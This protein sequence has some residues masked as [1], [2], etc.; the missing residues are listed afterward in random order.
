MPPSI[1]PE[2]ELLPPSYGG[3]PSSRQIPDYDR[4]MSR[5]NSRQ[6]GWNI[7][8]TPG[9]Y[10]LLGINCAVYIW[11]V[12]RGVSPSEP[13]PR[14]LIHFGAAQASLI[15]HGQWYRLITA[16]FV[17]VGLLHIATNMWC[18]WN[19]GLLGEPLLGPFG[20]IAVY[21][22]TGIAGNLLSL[23]INVV[24]RD[25]SV[26]AG[27]SGAVFGIA[28]IL[29]V[30]LSN[31]K[32]PIPWSELKRLRK[33]VIWFAAINLLI[34]GATLFVPV[35]R[36]DNFAHL[37]GFLSGLALGVPLIPR[38]TSGRVRY[39]RRQKYTFAAASFG[40]ALFGYWIANL[41]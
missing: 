25:N 12:L 28:G 20:L 31:K 7:L 19:L 39:L 11:M 27:A 2:G 15:L 17:H 37:G 18:L 16:T 34:G 3:S 38:M 41:R 9:T 21:F 6:R 24:I 23:F 33:S 4:E 13:T 5:P 8:V 32:L 40:L 14:D 26:G 35:I 22:L 30:L 36:I 1:Q 10:L 29:I